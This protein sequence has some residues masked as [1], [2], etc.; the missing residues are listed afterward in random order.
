MNGSEEVPLRPRITRLTLGKECNTM[1]G[2]KDWRLHGQERYL[3]GVILFHRRYRQYA[4]DPEWDHD[5]C[6]FCWAMFMVEDA[7]D[8]QQHG[9]ATEGD[10]WWIC[11]ACFNDFKGMFEWKVVDELA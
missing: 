10:Y 1:A 9:Y 2:Q 7:I 11:E 5:H 3:K 8:T 4:E 6:V